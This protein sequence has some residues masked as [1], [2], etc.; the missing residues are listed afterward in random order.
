MV[1][2]IPEGEMQTSYASSRSEDRLLLKKSQLLCHCIDTVAP[3][4]IDGFKHNSP[5]VIYE[6]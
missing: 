1:A 2:E 6:K 3:L 5:A 4:I